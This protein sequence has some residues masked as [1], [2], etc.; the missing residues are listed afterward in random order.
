ME[1]KLNTKFNVGTIPPCESGRVHRA[2]QPI[3][4][5]RARFF[6]L[7][8]SVR[9]AETLVWGNGGVE[10]LRCVL[11]V[12][13]SPLCRLGHAADLLP[14]SEWRFRYA[15]GFRHS[16]AGVP[17]SVLARGRSPSASC[18]RVVANG[19]RA[20]SPRPSGRFAPSRTLFAVLSR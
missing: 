7:N 6:L 18:W 3:R 20:F 1:Y 4:G 11:F 9:R 15:F 14:R 17:S 13:G 10:F 5:K 12:G 2:G 16:V 19:A 8:A